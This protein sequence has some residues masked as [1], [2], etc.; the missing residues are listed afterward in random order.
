[1]VHANEFDVL[2]DYG[3]DIEDDSYYLPERIPANPEWVGSEEYNLWTK[4]PL[5]EGSEIARK[6][7]NRVVALQRKAR[8][9]K[10]G[11]LPE[12]FMRFEAADK[13]VKSPRDAVP[14]LYLQWARKKY[15]MNFRNVRA[16]TFW[17]RSQNFSFIPSGIPVKRLITR[18]VL[19]RAAHPFTGQ[20]PWAQA[21]PPPGGIG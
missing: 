14:Q 2:R 12:L 18:E 11:N 17:E 7:R 20:L 9:G 8:K 3:L 21:T 1:M 4:D 6:E 15:G 16:V 13:A 19:S 5:F 10:G